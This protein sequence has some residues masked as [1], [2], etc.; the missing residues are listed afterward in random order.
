MTNDTDAAAG[1]LLHQL[2]A[3]LRPDAAP[4]E[5]V[6]EVLAG[7]VPEGQRT[8]AVL[9]VLHKLAARELLKLDDTGQKTY[10][11][12]PC[13]MW[14]FPLS[15]ETSRQRQLEDR[16]YGSSASTV[17]PNQIPE[18]IVSPVYSLQHC[19]LLKAKPLL[20]AR[21]LW[22]ALADRWC[23]VDAV[24]A[25][26]EV[27]SGQLKAELLGSSGTVHK[28]GGELMRWDSL[29]ENSKLVAAAKVKD[30]TGAFKKSAKE[31]VWN[32]EKFKTALAGLPYTVHK[33]PAERAAV[34]LKSMSPP[35]V[36]PKAFDPFSALR[37]GAG[38]KP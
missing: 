7:G 13:L 11:P 21:A 3:G 17:A 5:E 25:D 22:P 2:L 16:R 36:T 24:E 33:A 29:L 12:K 34:A 28:T 14:S 38:R 35:A 30:P 18:F 27:T 9:I 37:G 6:A 31:S 20:Q 4:L 19:E 8:E 26:R 15:Q 32:A 23:G 1:R 10:S